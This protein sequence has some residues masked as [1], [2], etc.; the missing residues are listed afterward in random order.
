MDSLIVESAWVGNSGS[1]HKKV[2]WYSDD[3]ISDLRNLVSEC[4][5]RNIPT[6]FYNKED[7]VH[8]SRFSKTSAMFD[9]VFTT[10]ENCIPKYKALKN[11]NIRDVD[12]IRF[13]AQPEFHHQN[14][15]DF[16]NRK[17]KLLPE[18]TTQG[19]IQID[20]KRWTCYLMHVLK[21]NWFF[22]TVN[23]TEGTH[24][25]CSQRDLRIIYYQN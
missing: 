8:F 19:S 2:G 24:N 15:T 23:Q 3:E 11:S 6:I 20:V 1:W 17:D 5:R 7:P 14:N 18:L 25:M 16:S 22:T 13:A 10:D 9:Q 4:R 12:Y 21:M